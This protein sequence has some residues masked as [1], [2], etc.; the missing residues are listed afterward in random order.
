MHIY[1]YVDIIYAGGYA[2]RPK[3]CKAGNE[4][5]IPG[6][7]YGRIISNYSPKTYCYGELKKDDEKLQNLMI[8]ILNYGASAQKYFNYRTSD[9]MNAN[10]TEEQQTISWDGSL[11]RSDWSIPEAKEGALTRNKTVF[12]SRGGHLTLLG[13]IDYT[14]Y[15]KVATVSVK[16]IKMLCWDET[17]YNSAEVLTRDN[18]SLIVDMKYV[19]ANSRYEY[20]YKGLP[21]KNMFS[22][23][24]ACAEVT[25]TNGSVYYSGVVAYCPERFSYISQNDSNANLA[26][27]ARCITIYGDAARKYFG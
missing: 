3:T 21:A 16:T 26:N 10:L 17:A 1:T 6:T 2:L 13:A 11:V 15:V 12:T 18:A 14:Y 9:L 25:D 20:T 7:L 5:K 23:I 22:P 4:Q 8:S 24:Y 19:S 27:L